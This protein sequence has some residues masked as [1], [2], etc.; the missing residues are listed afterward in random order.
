MI[1]FFLALAVA[2][3]TADSVRQTHYEQVLNNATDALDRL[4]GAAAGFRTD[5]PTASPNLVLGRAERVG[6]TCRDAGAAVAGVDSLL[7]EGLYVSRAQREQNE[8]KNGGAALRRE[9]AECERQWRV[10]SPPTYAAADSLRAWGP[11]RT[12]QLDASLRRYVA[13]LR[14]FMKRAGLRKPAVS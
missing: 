14:R 9:L 8:L 10:P 3:Q 13:V 1:S 5:L 11:Y 7:G 6:G 2:A 4:R 12:A